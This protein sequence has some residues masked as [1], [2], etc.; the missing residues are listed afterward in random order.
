MTNL[1]PDMVN[2]PAHYKTAA[3]IEAID[4]IEGYDLGFHL[5]NAMKYLLRAGRKGDAAEDLGKCC[6][7]LR[8]YRHV[9]GYIPLPEPADDRPSAAAIIAAFGLRGPIADA[10]RHLLGRH[11]G[12]PDMMRAAMEA[13]RHIARAIAEMERQ[14]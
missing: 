1:A 5:G 14:T 12:V 10:A 3:G 11:A 8:R 9:S 13:E 4:V 2:H 6:W 7:Y